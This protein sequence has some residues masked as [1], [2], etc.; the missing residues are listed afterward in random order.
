[1]QQGTAGSLKASPIYHLRVLTVMEFIAIL[2]VIIRAKSGL[3][4]TPGL[5]YRLTK[6]VLLLK[7]HQRSTR[8]GR[9]AGASTCTHHVSVLQSDQSKPKRG[10]SARTNQA[11]RAHPL[12]SYRH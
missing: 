9:G 4:G 10:T 2:T 5:Y 11:A 3:A 1:M 6:P 12:L 8:G 7:L